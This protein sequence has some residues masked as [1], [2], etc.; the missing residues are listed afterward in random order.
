MK[1]YITTDTHFNHKMLLDNNFRPQGYE[2]KIFEG[3]KNLPSDCLLIHLGDVCLGK[4]EE[5]HEKYIKPLKYRKWLIKGNHDHKSTNWYL[6]HGWDFVAYQFID[7]YYGVKI[8]FSHIPK[9][10]FGQYELNIHGHFHDTDHRIQEP[11]IQAILNNKQLLIALE[12]I[13]YQPF[14]LQKYF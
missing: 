10:D 2:E 3:L 14:N 9:E 7:R 11:E 12:H 4:D 1:I 13:D 8:L 5:M 6:N